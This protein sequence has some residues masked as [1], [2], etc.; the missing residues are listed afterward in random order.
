MET[1]HAKVPKRKGRV[2][3]SG[4]FTSWA[5]RAWVPISQVEERGCLTTS[6]K[7]L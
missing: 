5:V 3:T 1:S 4:D 7:K 2:K 6:R